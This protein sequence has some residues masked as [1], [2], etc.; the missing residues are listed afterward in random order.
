MF[1]ALLAHLQ[2]EALLQIASTQRGVRGMTYLL[3]QEGEFFLGG[4]LDRKL[5]SEL[6]EGAWQV[7]PRVQ[8]EHDELDDLT[9][10]TVEL[11]ERELAQQGF[12]QAVGT[13]RGVLHGLVLP[14][15]I[16][17][18]AAALA[19]VGIPSVALAH[20]QHGVQG[21]RAACFC[22]RVRVIAGAIRMLPF[23]SF[24]KGV[25][26][27]LLF[28]PLL[29]VQ[30]GKLENLHGLDHLRRLNESLFHP[31]GLEESELH[32]HQHASRATLSELAGEPPSLSLLAGTE[33]CATRLA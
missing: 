8:R 13:I 29:Q 25:L 19:Q 30:R 1:R 3:Q 12:A 15:R 18:R 10:A 2:E 20:G 21:L 28:D 31:G 24:Q 16:L 23:H 9:S 27:E 14:L 4:A 32:R 6:R 17:E 33:P 22:G 26:E 11:D 7:A 5:L